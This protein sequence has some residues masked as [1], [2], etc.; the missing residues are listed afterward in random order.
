LHLVPQTYALTRNAPLSIL[1]GALATATAPAG[2]V[3]VLQE[4]KAKGPV[5]T[6]LYDP[7]ICRIAYFPVKSLRRS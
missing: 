6:T 2:T 4:Y 7:E 5:T 3:D 1:L